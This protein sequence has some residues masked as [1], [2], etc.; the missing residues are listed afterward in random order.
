MNAALPETDI[1]VGLAALQYR[2]VQPREMALAL[3]FVVGCRQAGGDAPSLARAMVGLGLLSRSEA[4]GLLRHVLL[5][6]A[7]ALK[8]GRPRPGPGAEEAPPPK[9]DDE[10]ISGP[11]APQS[12]GEVKGYRILESVGQGSVGRVFR[13]HQVSMDRIVALKILSSSQTKDPASIQRFL[14]E[15]RSAGLLNHPNLI[16]V[17]EVKRSGDL[18]Y[19][20]MDYV[21]GVPLHQLMDEQPGGKLEPKRVVHIFQQVATAL[22]YGYR[23]SIIHREIRPKSIMITEGDQAKLAD[24]G[25]VKEE[26]SRFLSGENAHYVAPEQ[27]ES[28]VADTRTDV[29][30]LGCCLFHALAGAPPFAG[31]SPKDVLRARLVS[32]APNPREFAPALPE[33]LCALVMKMMARNP[34]QRYQTPGEVLEALKSVSFTGPVPASPTPA[35]PAPPSTGPKRPAPGYRPV[36]ASAARRRPYRR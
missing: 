5:G 28:T 35:S 4:V 15:A 14:T 3:R 9:M 2:Y 12:P 24:L 22:D 31:D 33:V 27:I 6:V 13:A 20:S 34:A 25:L 19:Y 10:R 36:R 8:Q 30:C 32:P 23:M 16:R 18:Y 26:T 1:L 21:D 17:H 7:L 11:D 29:Y